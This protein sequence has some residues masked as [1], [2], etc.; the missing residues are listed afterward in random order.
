MFE[1]NTVNWAHLTRAYNSLNWQW[2]LG[3]A[4]SILAIIL[5][6]LYFMYRVMPWAK[7]GVAEW[8]YWVGATGSVGAIFMAFRLATTE[9]RRRRTEDLSKARLTAIHIHMDL[10]H[11]EAVAH[12]VREN[13]RDIQLIYQNKVKFQGQ[14]IE[15]FSDFADRLHKIVPFSSSDLI[16]LV[17]LS[18]NCA[19]KIALGQ[20][21][22][23]ASAKILR[24]TI[25]TSMKHDELREHITNNLT[26]LDKALGAIEQA[27]AIVMEQAVP[28]LHPT[29]I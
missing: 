14:N 6:L 8:A 29:K 5:E 12:G 13:L 7:M 18:G 9:T 4:I 20:G 11:M 27:R 3:T 26:I 21:L 16:P 28:V 19:D 2:R 24:D 15:N 25:V 23:G 1:E 22:I 17:P 10:L